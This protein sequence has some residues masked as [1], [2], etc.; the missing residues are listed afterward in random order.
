VILTV[1]LGRLLTIQKA[2]TAQVVAACDVGRSILD[3][4]R[5][6]GRSFGGG[7][8]DGQASHLE[9]VLETEWP[10]FAKHLDDRRA[11]KTVALE[12]TPKELELVSTALETQRQITGDVE[13]A[14]AG[15]ERRRIVK[16]LD[17]V[18]DA[19]KGARP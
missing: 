5:L 4:G 6:P 12:L 2:T 19:L 18:T 17:R 7:G 15:A 11:P 1:Q 16:L 13:G 3:A 8:P 9:F 10:I 14:L